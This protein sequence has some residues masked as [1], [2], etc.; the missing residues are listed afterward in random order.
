VAQQLEGVELQAV[1]HLEVSRD[2]LR[3]RLHRRAGTE[4][5]GDD[6]AAVLEHRLDVYDAETAPMLDFYAKRG[7]V[8]DI[9]GEQPV[10]DVFETI[11]GAVDTIRE[12]LG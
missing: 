7:L 9:D 1:V 5:R 10:D 2:E 12:G 8:V 3:R 4:D 6:A 11:V